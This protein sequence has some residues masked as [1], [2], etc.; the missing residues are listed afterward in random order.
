M[1]IRLSQARAPIADHMVALANAVN[2]RRLACL[3][4]EMRQHPLRFSLLQYMSAIIVRLPHQLWISGCLLRPTLP[5]PAAHGD[6]FQHRFTRFATEECL[7]RY[8]PALNDI[9]HS[10]SSPAICHFHQFRHREH[11]PCI[12]PQNT[13]AHSV[14]QVDPPR[15]GR[16]IEAPYTIAFAFY[17][18]RDGLSD[19]ACTPHCNP[20]L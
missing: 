14:S 10:S 15:S 16:N 3:P 12:R 13:C 19:E 11:S 17:A 1:R 7:E 18:G 4:T 20:N 8:P 5:F 6:P 2:G 9:V